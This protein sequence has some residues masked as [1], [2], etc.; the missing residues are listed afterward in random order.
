MYTKAGSEKRLGITRFLVPYQS[1]VYR[2]CGRKSYYM[3]ES[4][5]GHSE[6]YINLDSVSFSALDELFK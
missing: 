1:D 5:D 2:P 6:V 4:F 3:K